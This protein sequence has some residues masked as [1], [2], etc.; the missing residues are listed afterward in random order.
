MRN[1]ICTRVR[2]C[3][4]VCSAPRRFSGVSL[5]RVSVGTG[6]AELPMGLLPQTAE[7]PGLSDQCSQPKGIPRLHRYG[8]PVN[9][10]WR[11]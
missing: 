2:F 3:G 5:V 6:V 11:T 10:P 9:L 4:R 8:K 1:N 7:Y